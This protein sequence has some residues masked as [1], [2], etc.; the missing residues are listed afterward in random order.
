MTTTTITAYSLAWLSRTMPAAAF[1]YYRTEGAA[2]AAAAK[3]Q[4][5][6]KTKVREVQVPADFDRWME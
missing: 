1:W 5:T 2:L 6:C 3:M 4:A